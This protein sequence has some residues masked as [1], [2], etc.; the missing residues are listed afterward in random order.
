MK[1]NV[2]S[3]EKVLVTRSSMNFDDMD[4]NS[5]LVKV[6]QVMND[7]EVASAIKNNEVELYIT[8]LKEHGALPQ[9]YSTRASK[10]LAQ[11]DKANFFWVYGAL[12]AVVAVAWAAVVS[13]V[14]VIGPQVAQQSSSIDHALN[15]GCVVT[16]DANESSS[17]DKLDKMI[18]KSIKEAMSDLPISQQEYASMAAKSFCSI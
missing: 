7:P 16:I 13:D 6:M 9:S 10:E 12:I 5:M 4:Q 2:S 14:I 17:D 1:K 8:L 15:S 18:D 11:I 3:P